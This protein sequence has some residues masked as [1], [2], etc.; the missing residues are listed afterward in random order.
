M[1]K[2]ITHGTRSRS[3]AGRAYAAPQTSRQMATAR[4][5]APKERCPWAAG[6]ELP[7]DPQRRDARRDQHD[8]EPFTESEPVTEKDHGED[9]K[10][11]EARSLDGPRHRDGREGQ[12]Q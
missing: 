6:A 7:G 9:G 3:T 1:E 4:T 2:T 12:G 11:H 10:D 8:A 5:T